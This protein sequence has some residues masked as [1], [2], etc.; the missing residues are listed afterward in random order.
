[1]MRKAILLTVLTA[2]LAPLSAQTEQRRATMTGAGGVDEGKC[3]IEVRVDSAAQVEI[4]GDRGV[5]RT[6]SGQ[7]ARWVRFECNGVMP[8]NPAD[9]AFRGVD[10]RGRQTLL[11]DPRNNR[12]VA[13]IGLE[14]RDGGAEGYTFDIVWQGGSAFGAQ[15]QWGRSDRYAGSDTTTSACESALAERAYQQYGSRDIRIRQMDTAETAGRRE[16]VSGIVEVRNGNRAGSYR[17]SC[18]VNTN[19]GRVRSVEIA[20]GYG[21]QGFPG[22]SATAYSGNACQ[23]G[24]EQRLRSEGYRNASVN[25]LN[26][27]GV[28][29]R[30]NRLTGTA[31]AQRAGQTY[32]FS[33]ACSVNANGS[34][35]AVD[36]ILQ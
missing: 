10:G 6:V 28:R 30:N 13:V 9:F 26:A 25:S 4:R 20:P 21:E 18:L 3:T 33:V 14:D 32:Q 34:V 27:G 2:T 23:Q 24:I 36:V 31:T 17:F 22:A 1:M 11:D 19:N 16:T 7:P 15:P 35:S 29:G 8:A 12:G 5:L